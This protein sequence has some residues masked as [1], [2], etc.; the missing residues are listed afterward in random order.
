MSQCRRC[1][2]SWE[3][4]GS[5]RRDNSC[6]CCQ[7]TP[8]ELIRDPIPF[9]DYATVAGVAA[10][11][12]DDG[13]RLHQIE[14]PLPN[15]PSATLR[16]GRVRWR[17]HRGEQVAK[18]EILCTVIVDGCESQVRSPADGFIYEQQLPP[19][20]DLNITFAF[21]IGSVLEPD[22]SLLRFKSAGA[23]YQTKGNDFTVWIYVGI[24]ALIGGIVIPC[25]GAIVGGLAGFH[26][27]AE[28]ESKKKSS[29]P[30][31]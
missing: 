6:F 26:Y 18:G 7:Y 31:A 8:G 1:G 14:I 10:M 30:R 27:Y 28:A 2:H 19:L 13:G 20:T 21:P 12:K 16:I 23:Y 9:P 3:Y 4:D 5:P 22:R 29:P 17:R 24:G 25:A 11:L 15:K